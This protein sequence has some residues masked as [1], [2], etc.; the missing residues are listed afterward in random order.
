MLPSPWWILRI[1]CTTRGAAVCNDGEKPTRKC[2]KLSRM[3]FS[4]ATIWSVTEGCLP[5]SLQVRR[6]KFMVGMWK[7]P[8]P[9][10]GHERDMVALIFPGLTLLVP[11]AAEMQVAARGI[12]QT[13]PH[14]AQEETGQCPGLSRT[15]WPATGEEVLW[16]GDRSGMP[17]LLCA[18]R[19]GSAPCCI[20]VA[21]VQ[22]I[23]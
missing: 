8:Q 22:T 21:M 4:E 6:E 20:A 10:Q 18:P 3:G 12:P 23:R 13:K 15:A 11:A 17:A 14:V 9:R 16:P 5:V 19:P 2:V 7:N 1:C